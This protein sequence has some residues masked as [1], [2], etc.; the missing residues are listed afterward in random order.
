MDANDKLRTAL[1]TIAEWRLPATGKFWD[2]AKT[3]PTSY[4]TEHGSQG[5]QAYMRRVAADALSLL[6]VAGMAPSD[7]WRPIET[8]PR[9]GTSVLVS[10]GTRGVHQVAWVARNSEGICIWS[11]DDGKFGPYPLRGYL[12]D[13]HP[14]SPTHWKPLPAAPSDDTEAL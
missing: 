5:S 10:F 6:P 3:R 14:T 11:V 4:E 13:G 12:S 2:D 8:V 9:D 1:E 7:Q